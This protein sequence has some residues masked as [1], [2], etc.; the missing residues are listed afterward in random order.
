MDILGIAE[1]IN[2]FLYR[3]E[4][5][6]L[7]EEDMDTAREWSLQTIRRHYPRWSEE[8]CVRYYHSMIN[9]RLI[10]VDQWSKRFRH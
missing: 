5:Q 9:I 10:A 8:Q 2:G 6:T 4:T 7:T 1:K 3:K